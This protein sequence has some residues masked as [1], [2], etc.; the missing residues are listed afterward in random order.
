M[1]GSRAGV[2]YPS[3]YEVIFMMLA[4]EMLI[5]ASIR[6][7]KAIGPTATTVGGLILGQAAQQAELVSSIMIIVTAF[8]AIA[9]F[10]I[11]INAMSFAI[12]CVRYPL[13][14]LASFFGIVGLVAGI[15]VTL[16]VLVDM[17]SFGTPFLA[18]KWGTSKKIEAISENSKEGHH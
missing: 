6:L 13:L 1:A 18:I 9:N 16:C 3:F 5:E 12:R 7:P 2:P 14:L 17:R 8:V 4:V 10:T 15:I 11:P